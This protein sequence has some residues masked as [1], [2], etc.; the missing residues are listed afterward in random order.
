LNAWCPVEDDT[1]S[2]QYY[3]GVEDFTVLARSSI[4]YTEFDIQVDNADKM[5][6]GYNLFYLSDMLGDITLDDVREDGCIII[7]TINWTC[8]LDHGDC[9]PS[10]TYQRSTSTGFSSGFNFRTTTY[11]DNDSGEIVRVLDKRYGVRITFETT[12]TG[13]QTDLV[14]LTIT[15]GSGLAYFSIASLIVDYLLFF[16]N[17]KN[18]QGKPFTVIKY[19]P[20]PVTEKQAEIDAALERGESYHSAVE[21]ES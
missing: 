9:P 15:V 19:E 3:L 17:P 5:E 21:L 4:V 20:F 6:F 1:V 7:A 16:I 18:A 11:Y 8:N 14:S 2:A 12:G 13:Y 10:F